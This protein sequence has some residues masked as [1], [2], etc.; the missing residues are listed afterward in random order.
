MARNRILLSEMVSDYI[1]ARGEDDADKRVPYK[2]CEANA[3]RVVRE[4]A[5]NVNLGFALKTVLIT[6]QQGEAY[7]D[8]PSDYVQYTKVG[9]IDGN[10]EVRTLGRNDK[11]RIAAEFLLDNNGNPLFDNTGEELKDSEN[12]GVGIGG[13]DTQFFNYLGQDGGL[14]QL[15]G[16]DTSKNGYGEYRFNAELN[17]FEV[18]NLSTSQVVLEYVYD[19]TKDSDFYVPLL[20]QKA[21][22][23]GIYYYNIVRMSYR[24]IPMNEK[25]RAK[26]DYLSARNVAGRML[27]GATIN[28]IVQ[29]YRSG[30]KQ[31]TKM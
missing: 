11:I 22:E 17:R 6:I 29:A 15:Y 21:I 4:M 16:W 30:N 9:V 2:T 12:R 20:S 10:G 3:K 28:E 24:F 7:F 31:S 13:Y 25:E 8:L 18:A 23:T 1:A 26:R 14:Y 27:R 5:M 19:L